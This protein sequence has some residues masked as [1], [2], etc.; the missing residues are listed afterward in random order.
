MFTKYR[1]VNKTRL[2][3]RKIESE[4]FQKVKSLRIAN[5]DRWSS[6]VKQKT[7]AHKCTNARAHREM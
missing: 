5:P 6:L 2:L 7:L 1:C 3:E 4:K